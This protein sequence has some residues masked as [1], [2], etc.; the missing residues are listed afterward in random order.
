MKFDNIMAFQG[1]DT[2]MNLVSYVSFLDILT[3]F[4]SY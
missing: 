4:S 1:G 2:L 3:D